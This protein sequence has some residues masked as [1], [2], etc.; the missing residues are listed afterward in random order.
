MHIAY[1]FSFAASPLLELCCFFLLLLRYLLILDAAVAISSEEEG[2]G[3]WKSLEIYVSGPWYEMLCIVLFVLTATAYVHGSNALFCVRACT[4]KKSGGLG[5]G[6]DTAEE[7]AEEMVELSP[8][9]RQ[10]REER[11]SV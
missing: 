10:E 3:I 11:P 2:A 7:P 6:Q 4:G 5:S 8:S 1:I 9:P